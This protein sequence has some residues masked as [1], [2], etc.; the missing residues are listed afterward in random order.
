ME[1]RILRI[2]GNR[3]VLVFPGDTH[4]R[5]A[6]AHSF[7]GGGH[8]AAP[9]VLAAHYDRAPDSP[10]ANDNSAAVFQLVRAAMTLQEERV[11]GWL[12]IF[13]DKEELSLR[14]GLRD[15]GA[16]S[17]AQKLRT[18]PLKRSSF[19]IFDACGA[20]DTLVISTMTDHL[21]R[22][23]SGPG[24][25]RTRY[26]IRRLRERA[27]GTARFLNLNKVLLAPTPFSDDAGFLRAGAAAQTITVLPT[28]EAAR[29]ASLKHNS[30]FI[31]ALVS[32]EA[33]TPKTQSLLPATWRSLNSPADT[34]GLLTPEHY[35]QVVRFACALC[36][37]QNTAPD[38]FLR[39]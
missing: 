17:L 32:R 37:Y 24:A 23:K 27:L 25:V 5:R 19:Y 35:Y 6:A 15:Q 20:G 31:S 9:V 18:T 7:Y 34:A 38:A 12:I 33:R 36:K 28:E 8:G 10:G 26:L 21:I 11:S 13:T 16:Y 22:D 39:A 3:H 4:A 1:R 29:L 14:E 2:N 30:A